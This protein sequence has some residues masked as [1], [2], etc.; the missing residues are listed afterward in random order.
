M[1]VYL[2]LTI[3]YHSEKKQQLYTQMLYKNK[4]LKKNTNKTR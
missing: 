2:I 3:N 1:Y 4:Y